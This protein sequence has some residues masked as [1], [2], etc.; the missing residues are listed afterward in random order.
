VTAL[1]TILSS[2]YEP[3]VDE[4]FQGDRLDPDRWLP[5]YL[6]Q[7][8][9]RERS[10]ARYRLTG[11]LEL[12]IAADQ[13]PWSPELD[14]DLR[15]SSLQTGLF[16]GPLGSTIGQHRRNPRAAV[17]EEQP[18]LR[19]ITPQFGAIE[20]RASWRPD[21]D[22]MVALWLIGF[23]DEPHRSAEI[24]VCEIFGSE[25]DHRHAM[26]GMGIHPFGDPSLND[27]FE[28]VDL[29]IDVSSTHEYA[30]VWESDHVEFFVDG[31]PVKRS[32]Q[33]PQYPMQLMLNIYCFAPR[34]RSVLA[35]PFVVDRLRVHAAVDDR[36]TA[37]SG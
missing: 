32:E 24:C 30:V 22:H 2:R 31:E 13:E 28:K 1:E 4:R 27:D 26:V 25:A 11:H 3:V 16:A 19:L 33:A 10:K 12:F 15:V 14:G 6:P 34:A 8:A 9:G 20:L 7:W 5:H 36:T 35:A 17:V 18:E 29:P 23:E 21:P 37:R